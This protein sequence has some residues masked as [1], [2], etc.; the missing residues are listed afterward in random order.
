MDVDGECMQAD[1]NKVEGD[2]F[3]LV[4]DICLK[5]IFVYLKTSCHDPDGTL[6]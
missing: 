2:N 4:L 6:L 3:S 5:R 1:A